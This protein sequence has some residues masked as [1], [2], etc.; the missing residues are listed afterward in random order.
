VNLLNVSGM[1]AGYTLGM[2]PS[3]AERLIVAVKGTFGLPKKQGDEPQLAAE[4]LPLV[5]ADQFTGEPGHSAALV[6]CD[7]ALEKPRCDV[8]LNGAA[9]A[10]GERP[11]QR[12][13]V[14]LQVGNWRKI[15]AV[16][17]D[18]VWRNAGIGFVPSAPAPFVRMPISYD[19]AFGG[20]DDQLRDPVSYRQYPANPV[21]R[22]WHYHRYVERVTGSP[23]PN[24]EEPGD[25]VRDPQGNYR[26][27]AFGPTGRGWPPRNKLAGTYDKAWLDNVF[28]FLPPDFDPRYF[29]SAPEDQQIPTP[30]GGEQIVL[31]NLTPD[32]RREFAFPKVDMPIIFFRRR[33]GPVEAKGTID[34][35][36]IEPDAERYSVVWRASLLLQRDIFEVSQVVT[37]QRSRAWWR[38]FKTGKTYYS[39]LAI[40]VREKGRRREDE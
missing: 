2:D 32:G 25:P 21:G 13:M 1:A 31:I 14:G 27:M 22:G 3:G 12:L 10:P 18:R 30:E 8:L 7:F 6:E 15:F 5:D 11:T 24:T 28:P 17:G 38:S 23:L 36:L 40:A 16:Y 34:T 29:Q 35:I 4:Q 26:P 9:Y 20:T 37:G 39:S 19:N 33:S